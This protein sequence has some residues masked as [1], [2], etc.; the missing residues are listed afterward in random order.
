MTM[1]EHAL[2]GLK[3]QDRDVLCFASI[4]QVLDLIERGV[5]SVLI[6]CRTEE[7]GRRFRASLHEFID[8]RPAAQL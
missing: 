8:L 5:P 3:H 1:V 7:P 6:A 2:L 4:G